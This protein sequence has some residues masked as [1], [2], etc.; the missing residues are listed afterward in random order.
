MVQQKIEESVARGNR[1]SRFRD[2]FMALTKFR[3][4]FMVVFTTMFGYLVATKSLGGYSWSTLFHVVFGTVLAAFGSSVYNQLMEVDADSKMSR[5]S[6]RP[7]PSDRLPKPLAFVIGW[8][9]CAFGIIHLGMMVNAT[10]AFLAAATLVTYLFVYT[11]MKKRSSFNTVVGAV[12][13]AFPPLIGWV[14][15]GGPLLTWGAAYLFGLLFFWQLPH[16]VAINW[17]YRE[18]YEK[19]GFVMW[20][21]NDESGRKSAFLATIFSACVLI[22]GVGMVFSGI[23]SMWAALFEFLLG[24]VMLFL[25]LRFQKS[26]ERS[27][28]RTLFFYT[29][30]YLP[31]AMGLAYVAW[32]K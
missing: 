5:T 30:I 24:G 20:S 14:G 23:M 10:A 25:A 17:M 6:D 1:P 21:N 28:A 15:G 32:T 7:L 3:L 9:L 18:E 26:R 2:D 22:F 11:P 8:L 27:D 19:G 16:F 12:S 13:G 31:L 29:L 4:S